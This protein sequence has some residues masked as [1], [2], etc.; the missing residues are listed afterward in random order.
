MGSPLAPALANIFMSFYESKWLNKYDLNKPNFYWR[1]VLDILAAFGNEQDS[2]NFL[3]FLNKRHP[4]IKFTIE[5]EISHSMAF[6]D[7]FILSIS[8]QNLTLQT[9]HKSTY[10]NLLL[11]FKSFTSF[12]FK[13]SLIKCLIDRLFE[14][15]NNWNSF[16]NDIESIKSNL[17][18]NAYPP[19]LIDKVIKRYLNYKF[20]SN[21]NQVKDTSDVHYF[22]LPYI[23][24]LSHHIRNKLSKLC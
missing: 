18:K 22:K 2:L 6:L 8:D 20:S 1:Y 9:Y 13:I 12:S 4:N 7:V 3:D 21:W 23:G 10:T 5:K 15:C 14:I 24:N 19:F 11:N 17:I 16:H